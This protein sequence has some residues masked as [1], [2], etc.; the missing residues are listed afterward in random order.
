MVKF[1]KENNL[2]NLSEVSADTHLTDRIEA[3]KEFKHE[4]ASS[5]LKFTESDKDSEI[6]A[7]LSASL[8]FLMH[9]SQEIIRGFANSDKEIEKTLFLEARKQ[10]EKA[11]KTNEN[12]AFLHLEKRQEAENRTKPTEKPYKTKRRAHDLCIW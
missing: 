4:V 2:I 11:Y 12:G 10:A 6:E 3:L 8:L 1:T 9:I 7:R 5:L